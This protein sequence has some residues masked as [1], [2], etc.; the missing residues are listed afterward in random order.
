MVKAEEKWRD[1][2]KRGCYEIEEQVQGH[3]NELNGGDTQFI[4][5]Q[6]AIDNEADAKRHR[7]D[8][9]YSTNTEE[10]EETAH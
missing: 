1:G 2:D 7:Q 4:A 3:R 6:E 9:G 5:S 10:S 8:D